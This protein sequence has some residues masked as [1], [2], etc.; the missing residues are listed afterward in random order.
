MPASARNSVLL[1]EPLAPV[2]RVERPRGRTKVAS[3]SRAWPL[4]RPSVRPAAPTIGRGRLRAPPRW[5]CPAWRPM[6]ACRPCSRSITARSSARVGVVVDEER[7][8][9]S[10]PGR[11]PRPSASSTPSVMA[12]A[13]KRGAVTTIGKDDGE[14]GVGR[15]DRGRAAAWVNSTRQPLAKT[16]A[17]RAFSVS[18]SRCLAAV[19]RDALG[20]LA[21]AHQR[22]AEVGLVALLLEVER[23]QP[24]ADEVGEER[25]DDG[26]DQATHTM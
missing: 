21:H 8:R 9:L 5:R 20:V 15:P 18:A 13:K 4:G 17:K 26:I 12:P 1:P 14:L 25:A 10:A 3:D 19:E 2:I 16:S 7:Q 11:R 24:P 23:D 6:A 22:E